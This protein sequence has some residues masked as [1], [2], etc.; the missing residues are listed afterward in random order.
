VYRTNT[1][2]IRF[3]IILATESKFPRL[4]A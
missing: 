4:H 2:E 3:N 1:Q